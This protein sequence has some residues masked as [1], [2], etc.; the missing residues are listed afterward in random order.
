MV[1]RHETGPQ[2][3]PAWAHAGAFLVQER[4]AARFV[5]LRIADQ[6]RHVAQGHTGVA[7]DLGSQGRIVR[8][9]QHPRVRGGAEVVQHCRGDRIPAKRDGAHCHGEIDNTAS[10]QA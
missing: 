1:L 3:S 2:W 4:D 8:G 10:C 5:A 7:G 6:R 9:K